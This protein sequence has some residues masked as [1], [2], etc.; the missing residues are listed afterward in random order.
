MVHMHESLF[1]LFRWQVKCPVKCVFQLQFA[2]MDHYC[3][4]FVGRSSLV[5]NFRHSFNTWF[6]RSFTFQMNVR[7]N[8]RF[9]RIFYG[10]CSC[11]WP[12]HLVKDATFLSDCFNLFSEIMAEVSICSIIYAS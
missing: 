8:G 11:G 10:T 2:C 1:C 12:A 7:S 9:K 4:Y 6:R 5:S 3:F